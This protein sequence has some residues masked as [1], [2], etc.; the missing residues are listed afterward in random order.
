MPH[1][2]TLTATPAHAQGVVFTLI[3]IRV[4]LG[5]TLDNSAGGAGRVSSDHPGLAARSGTGGG[6]AAPTY[7]LRPLAINV[8]VS[9]EQD[10]ASPDMFDR[11]EPVG[12]LEVGHAA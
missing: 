4:G 6:F 3:I 10:R 12:D 9:R 2:H 7:P 1:A 11:K 8:S 5:Y